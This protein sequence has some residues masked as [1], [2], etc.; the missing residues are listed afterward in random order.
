MGET[1]CNCSRNTAELLQQIFNQVGELCDLAG[2]DKDKWQDV[3]SL[4]EELSKIV[5]ERD[6]LRKQV[7]ELTKAAG[8]LLDGVQ[9]HEMPNDT[10]ETN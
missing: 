6:A 7:A 8:H 3:W 5:K 9:H 2:V 10:K 1:P 4:G